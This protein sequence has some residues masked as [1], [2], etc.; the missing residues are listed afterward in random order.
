[1]HNVLALFLG[2]II[3]GA[4]ATPAPRATP[5]L[6]PLPAPAG[7]AWA[8]GQIAAL[9]TRLE[10][11]LSVPTLRGAMIGFHAID[12]VR[13]SV[14]YSRN[15]DLEFMP[16]SNFKLLVGS[17]VL[18]K[19]GTGFTYVTRIAADAAPSAGTIRGN[20]YL[21][22]GG[23]ALLTA[24]DLD[25]A[26]SSLAAQGVRRIEGDVVT[27]A[28]HFDS[29]PYGFGWSWDDLP[30]YYAPVESA[31]E[32]EDGVVHVDFIAGAKPGDPIDLRVWPRSDAYTIDN[33][34]TTGPPG[35]KDT[36]D[37]A[38]PWT[39]FSTIQFTG[40]YPL[41]AKESGDVVPAVPDPEA[42]A[43]DVLLRALRAHGITVTGA[44]RKGATP[45]N[46]AALWMH[47]SEA[48]PQL[49]HDFWYPSDNLMGELF[50]KE[51]GAAQAGEPGS[52][53]KGRIAEQAFLRTA[54]IDPSTVTVG[55][56]SGL[57]QYSRITPR[58]F[59]SILQYDWNSAN[60][61]IVLRAL[62]NSGL[63][64]TLGRAYA[65]TPAQD[66]VF[67]KTGSINHVRT[68]SGFVQTRT[69]GPV[70]FSL[71]FNGW[72][73]EDAA[74]GAADLGRARAAILSALA[75]Q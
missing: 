10:R 69:H 29:Q 42:F 56:G 67:A 15:A 33:Q 8:A 62:P 45:A 46:P 20:L 73:G 9:H 27:D 68:L 25:A 18:H 41:G 60:R 32:L 19:L 23:D 22:G 11:A 36:T 52:D 64:G 12:T 65:G 5:V 66:K 51:L 72:M 2:A 63:H 24:S 74:T 39:G 35:S 28:T 75:T 4:P 17:A 49:L 21:R 53:D 61:N 70:T 13:H 59:V 44:L 6:P 55:D 71:L 43:G 31:L 30:Y 1:M 48:M 34:I 40:S 58:D 14:V 26:A 50:L 47:R 7:T 54:G 16:A 37:I 38:R 3:Y 57:S